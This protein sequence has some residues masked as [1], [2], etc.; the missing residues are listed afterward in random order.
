MDIPYDVLE[1]NEERVIVMPL[2]GV[3]KDSIK[4]IFENEQ[5]VIQWNREKPNL[6][7]WLNAVQEDCFWWKFKTV[8]G[9]PHHVYVDRIYVQLLQNNT[10]IIT[11][12]KI[13]IP[14]KIDLEIQYL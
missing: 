10:L 14:S 9:L 8:I 11:I 12:P 6:K 2:G 7:D 5:L 3:E 1:N 13:I 4:C